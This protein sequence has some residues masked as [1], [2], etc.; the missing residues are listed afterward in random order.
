VA[1][2]KSTAAQAEEACAMLVAW[3]EV[4]QK[5]ADLAGNSQAFRFMEARAHFEAMGQEF[6]GTLFYGNSGITPKEFTGLAPRYNSLSGTNAQNIISGGGA[7]SDNSSI[8]LVGWGDNAVH[9]IYPKGSQAGLKHE[10]LGLVTVE[11]TA[12]VGGNR[13]RAYQ[14]MFTW[15]CGLVVKDWRYAVRGCNIDISNLVAKSSA[16]DVVEIMIKMSHR[17]PNLKG[18][19]PVFYMNRTVFQMLDIFRRDDVLSGGQLSYNVVDGKVD[20]SFRGI[21]IHVCDQLHELEAAVV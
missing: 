10:D 16:A 17:I 6:A 2:T 11:T 12:G 21:P 14:D 1:P 18:C 5:L 20:Y 9:G 13:M 15:D 4:D 19:K 3:S 7:G 8:W